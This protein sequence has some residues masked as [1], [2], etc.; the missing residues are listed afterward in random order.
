MVLIGK[1]YA[2]IEKSGDEFP[3]P[4]GD[5]G[6]YQEGRKTNL[7][8]VM[9]EFPSP[10]GDCDSY[11]LRKIYERRNSMMFPS[12]YGDCGSYRCSLKTEYRI[13][14]VRFRPLTGIVVLIARGDVD[15]QA[16]V[17]SCFRPLTG[18][19]VLI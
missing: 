1:N 18:I 8:M 9:Y 5:C 4:Y 17:K 10:Y 16:T 3:S 14:Q 11:R 12:P 13:K 6:S 19:V 2:T 15:E 7:R